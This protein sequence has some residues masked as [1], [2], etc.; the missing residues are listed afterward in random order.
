VPAGPG[1]LRR[2]YR[3]A[4]LNTFDCYGSHSY[5]HLKTD[6]EIRALVSELQPDTS[7]VRNMDRYFLRPPPVGIALRLRK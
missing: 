1:Y 7:L 6:D 3:S 2:A 4:A 5:Q